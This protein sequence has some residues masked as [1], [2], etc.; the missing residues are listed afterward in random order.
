MPCDDCVHLR[1]FSLA[2]GGRWLMVTITFWE[3]CRRTAVEAAAGDDRRPP[4]RLVSG[5]QPLLCRLCGR[6][7]GAQDFWPTQRA[8]SET[9]FAADH[10]TTY[11]SLRE[12]IGHLLYKWLNYYVRMSKDVENAPS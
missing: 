1:R 2:V 10:H 6:C 3:H 8:T 7:R 5:P 9:T 4:T 12:Y 11:G